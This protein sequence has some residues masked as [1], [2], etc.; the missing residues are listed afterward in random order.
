LLVKCVVVE[1]SRACR[2]CGRGARAAARDM[3]A[4]RD[5]WN[6]K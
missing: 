3:V 5:A 2:L 1:G 6:P 4:H